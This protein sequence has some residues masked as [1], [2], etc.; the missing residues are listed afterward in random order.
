V[1][2]AANYAS[3]LTYNALT[4]LKQM[5]LGN[6]AV[7]SYAYY[8]DGGGAP[9]INSFRLWQVNTSKSG[10]TLLNLQYAYDNVGNVMSI[11]DGANSNQVQSFTYDAL[12]R[13]QS[14]AT[15]AVGNGQYTDSYTYT[16][17][18][19]LQ[20]KTGLGTYAYAS[21]CSGGTSHAIPHAVISTTSGNSYTY[22]CNGNMLT[23]NEGGANFTQQWNTENRLTTV[24]GNGQSATYT[25]DGDG[26]LRAAVVSGSGVSLAWTDNSSNE[27]SFEIE[28][29]SDGVSFSWIGSVGANVSSYTDWP[30]CGGGVYAAPQ[31]KPASGAGPAIIQPPPVGSTTYFY[32][33]RAHNAGGYSG[34]S[35][36]A[37]ATIV[38]SILVGPAQAGLNAPKSAQAATLAPAPAGQ[39]WRSY[40]FAGSTRVAMRVDGDPDATK[41]GVFYL[42]GDHLGSTSLTLD[43]NG[44]KIGELRYKPFGETRYTWGSTPTD[45]RFTGQRSEEATLG[46][47]YDY[48]ARFYSP[49]VGRFISADSI[50]PNESNPQS[51]NRYSYVNNGPLNHTDPTGHITTGDGCRDE[52][53]SATQNEIDTA[54]GNAQYAIDNAYYRGCEQNGGEGCPKPLE[55]A[56]FGV[57]GLAL[58]GV[59][60][61]DAVMAAGYA[62]IGGYTFGNGIANVGNSISTGQP[63]YFFGGWNLRDAALSYTFS[64]ITGGIIRPG[65][66]SIIKPALPAFAARAMASG[67][68]GGMQYSAQQLLSGGTPDGRMFL[69]QAGMSSIGSSVADTTIGPSYQ[70]FSSQMARSTVS[71]GTKNAII[72]L[73]TAVSTWIAN[74][75]IPTVL[76]LSLPV[77]TK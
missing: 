43:S 15:N 21:S 24:S 3:G 8:G 70:D 63:Y 62:G 76:R 50:I 20:S 29:S 5:T 35:N 19:N 59:G 75:V 65:L 16:P 71:N 40:Y 6:G 49:V 52:G 69:A 13:L 66:T 37:S 56:A 39:L 36:T 34:Y 55:I 45:R 67:L 28:R 9:A 7:T 12:D 77:P 72:G 61:V 58:A 57:V 27:D 74:T 31:T 53:C 68:M 48:G 54:K 26:N 46:S 64:G 17:I 32:R 38:C 14:A 2:G 51:L 11:M 10:S 33:V 41:N 18:G 47:L 44:N 22:D 73:T 30:P 42:V 4:Q 25:Y 60:S 1:S 23:R